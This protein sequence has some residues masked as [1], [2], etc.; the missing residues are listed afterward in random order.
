MTL[1]AKM[2]GQGEDPLEDRATRLVDAARTMAFAA[3]TNM[4]DQHRP[5]RQVD[6][7]QIEYFMTVAGVFIAAT[8]LNNL[9]VG[10]QRED[11]LMEIVANSLNAWDPGGVVGFEDCKNLFE[12]ECQRLRAKEYPPQF[13]HSDALGIWIVWN[14]LGHSPGNEEEAALVRATGAL[15]THAFFEWWTPN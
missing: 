5:L 4:G 7:E 3:A 10:E 11:R 12:S 14:L 9:Q 2:S 6:Q 15:V 1:F 8:R 13:L